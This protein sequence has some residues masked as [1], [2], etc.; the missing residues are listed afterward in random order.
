MDD[1]DTG[2]G[3]LVMDA[4]SNPAAQVPSGAARPGG[5][6][7]PQAQERPQPPPP[8]FDLSPPE[9][10]TSVDE[11]PTR[12]RSEQELAAQSPQVAF[13]ANKRAV[14]AAFAL[15][16]P[17]NASTPLPGLPSP[18]PITPAAPDPSALGSWPLVA[19]I[20][21]SPT[22]V[23][24]LTTGDAPVPTAQLIAPR[25]PE[26]FSS[27]DEPAPVPPKRSSVL[28]PLAIGAGAGLFVTAIVVAVVL[29]GRDDP[30]PSASPSAGASASSAEVAT[31]SNP[32]ADT[33]PISAP[34]ATA[35]AAA[36]PPAATGSDAKAQA[37]LAKL[38]DGIATCVKTTIH[39]LPGASPAVPESLAWLKSGPYQSLKRDWA[40]PFF[41]CT[42]FKVEEPM[43][44]VI[45]WQVDE[46][47]EKGTGVAWIDDDGDGK[48]ERAYGFKA[49]LKQRDEVS[50]GPI[51][52]IE[53]TRKL[54]KARR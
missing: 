1:D 32:G 34:P 41:A 12:Q 31:A 23:M 8:L 14:H 37:A 19:P 49:T 21:P 53:P 16:Q 30:G 5:V 29:L 18:A 17:F 42:R 40:S 22:A 24:P 38:R 27:L 11:P 43:P 36:P 44:F 3:T 51:E 13:G 47:N 26:E 25:V 6:P 4:G 10:S 9:E 20:G 7:R 52:A 48:A 50:F 33:S 35:T 45:Q 46:P 28:A 2:G 15:T 39:V 54:Q